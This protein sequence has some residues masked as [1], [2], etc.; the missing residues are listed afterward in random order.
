MTTFQA[1]Q[2]LW[3]FFSKKE[4]FMFDRDYKDI[5][6]ISEDPDTDKAAFKAALASLE[7]KEIINKQL[8]DK[9][10][11]IWVLHK[12]FSSFE[13]NVSIGADV[14]RIISD[15][16]N[17]YC[18]STN[19]TKNLCNCLEITEKDLGN[20]LLIINNLLNSEKEN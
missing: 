3:K 11:E 4:S 6:L 16:I 10:K 5:V 2:E 18:E 12:P 19:D 15:T 8:T 9:N 14:S 13:Q 20:L 7:K 1:L 17:K